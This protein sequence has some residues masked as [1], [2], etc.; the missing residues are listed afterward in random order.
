MVTSVCDNRLFLILNYKEMKE[1]FKLANCQV[2]NELCKLKDI[3]L[4][5]REIPL[6]LRKLEEFRS[7][8]NPEN[9]K[10]IRQEVV[11]AFRL[12]VFSM[13]LEDF[14][15]A[16]KDFAEKFGIKDCEKVFKIAKAVAHDAAADINIFSPSSENLLNSRTMRIFGDEGLEDFLLPAEVS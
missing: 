10:Q 8:Q 15:N 3:L 13:S 14:E 5:G 12:L 6:L 4:D 16:D 7:S 9:E 2:V 11:Q 1:N